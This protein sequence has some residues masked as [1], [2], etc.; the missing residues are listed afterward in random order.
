MKPRIPPINV[1]LHEAGLPPLDDSNTVGVA[2]VDKRVA[3]GGDGAGNGICGVGEGS[4][5]SEHGFISEMGT[6][7]EDCEEV[8][9]GADG[10][11]SEIVI[12]AQEETVCCQP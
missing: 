10:D 1:Q 2:R 8:D 7:D 5:V 6:V 9:V 4:S 12:F 3:T 11:G